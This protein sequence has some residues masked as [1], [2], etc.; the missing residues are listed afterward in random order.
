M[1]YILYPVWFNAVQTQK[2]RIKFYIRTLKHDK[3]GSSQFSPFKNKFPA[4]DITDAVKKKKSFLFVNTDMRN[5][6]EEYFLPC[7][8]EVKDLIFLKLYLLYH[9]I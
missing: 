1:T 3:R 6:V 8:E 9:T 5:L 2:E 4:Q 7:K